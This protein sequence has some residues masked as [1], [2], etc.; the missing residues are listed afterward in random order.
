MSQL[1]T[2]SSLG[3]LIKSNKKITLKTNTKFIATI[4]IWYS[5]LKLLNV[6]F[7]KG[8]QYYELLMIHFSG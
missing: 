4:S 3:N 2:F 5:G 8:K 7:Q 6:L 1:L